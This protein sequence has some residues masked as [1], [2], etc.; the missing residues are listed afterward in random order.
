MGR[1]IKAAAPREIILQTVEEHFVTDLGFM[2]KVPRVKEKTSDNLL[3]FSLLILHE[4]W[5]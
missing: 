3:D 5:D 4:R 2:A 1:I